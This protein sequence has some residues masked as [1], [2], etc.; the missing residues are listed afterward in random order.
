[1]PTTC[2]T[3]I[4]ARVAR[5]TRLDVCG[6][7]VTG[8]GNQA[9]FDGFVQI[10]ASSEYEE[11]EEF[12][13]KNA[14]GNLCVIDKDPNE[15]K[16]VGLSIEMCT[17]DPDVIVIMTGERLLVTGGGVTGTGV[18]FG[19]GILTARFSVEVWQP[20]SGAQACSTTGAQQFVYW[21]FPNV[22]NAMM[23]DFTFENGTFTL[24]VDAETK[25]VGPLWGQGYGP[26]TFAST[27]KYIPSAIATGEHYG[28]NIA[29]I[30]PP[31]AVCGAF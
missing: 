8:A 27:P 19:D 13:L 9:V 7:P 12:L 22:G 31:S 29:A 18:V 23:G 14:N 1:M 5:V 26:T 11:G 20:I 6:N 10:A 2:F 30:P 16:R 3:P 21:V 4:K 28:F 15:L 17:I 24:T 25:A